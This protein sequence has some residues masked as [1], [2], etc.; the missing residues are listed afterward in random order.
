MSKLPIALQLYTLR[1]QTAQDFS[2]T[3]RKVADIGYAAV[4]LAGHGDLSIRE[5]VSLLQDNHLRV[6]GSHVGIEAMEQDI[7]QVIDENLALGNRYVVVPYLSED[8]RQGA[9]GYKRTAETLNGLG[10][11]LRSNALSLCY[12]NHDFEFQKQDNGELG[13]DILLQNTDPA[14]V[15]AE[16][17]TYWVLV[18]GQDP[19]EFVQKYR[20]RVPLM[21]LKDRDKT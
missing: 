4:E 20:G 11:T 13:I 6:A 3:I 10:E 14:L 5:L 15:K 21:H 9:D 7:A 1:D 17:D 16:V 18:G 2:G 12:H 19:V 8:R